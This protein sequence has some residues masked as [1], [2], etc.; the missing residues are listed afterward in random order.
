MTGLVGLM[1][2]SVIFIALQLPDDLSAALRIPTER[3]PAEILFVAAVRL[4]EEG[5]VSLAKAAEIAGVDRFAFTERL[6]ALG[7]PTA[8]FD[9]EDVAAAPATQCSRA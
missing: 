1:L 2:S 3:L 8:S 5:R 7:L 6:S 4:Y 9:S